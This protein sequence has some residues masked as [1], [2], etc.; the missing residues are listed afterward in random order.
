MA[1]DS[2]SQQSSRG[3]M[4]S[5]YANLLDPST[6]STA[7]TPGTISRAPVV[8]KQPAGDESQQDEA[9][10]RKHQISAENIIAETDCSRVS[11]SPLCER[12]ASLRFQPTKRPQITTQ[13]PKSKPSLPK[14]APPRPVA[15]PPEATFTPAN[16]SVRSVVKTTLAD[17]TAA[18]DDDDVNGFYGGEKRQRG[19]R[20]KR[21]KN[22]E[23][24]H[25]PQNWDDIYEPS[26]PN[27]Y[28]EYKNS[29]EKIREVR[30]WKDR[31]YAHRMARKHSSDLDSEDEEQQRT[32]MSNQFAPPTMSFAPPP[33]FD[34]PATADSRPSAAIPEYPTG[35]DAYTRRLRLSQQ[36]HPPSEA[37]VA[38]PPP[39]PPPL[40]QPPVNDPISS[41]PPPPKEPL[42]GT[43]S[44]APVRYN[45]PSAP[46][47]L[48]KSEAE[49]EDALQKE[50]SG[51]EQEEDAPRS[52]RPGQKGFAERLMSKYGW[53]KGS[54][55]GA[56]GSGI[57]NPLRVQI[58][59]QKKKPDAEGGGF[60]GPGGRGKI[61]GGKKKKNADGGADTEEGKFGAMSEVIVLRGM[62]NGMDLDA[63][64]ESAGDGGL[65]QEI[66]EECGEKY[67]RVER[68][69]IDRHNPS[70][71][72]VFV[73]FTSQLSALRAVNA[74]EG[75]IFNGNTISARFFDVEKFEKGIYE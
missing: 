13:K 64:L 62:V 69:F 47:D 25:V 21:K 75:R 57:V 24:S 58:E 35:E 20:K 22:R 17:W 34:E 12:T 19:G 8:F 52:V 65:M 11:G 53:T 5:L 48:P 63:E 4:V 49:L 29:D 51:D 41:P 67:G 15:S 60:V 10:A 32:Q 54:G 23:E 1:P 66:G 70:T 30:E 16:G 71:A 18:G 28:E 43:I 3:G 37:V 40:D 50:E 55:L 44:R 39:P 31:L 72:P 27:N 59:K 74:L 33:D 45:L 38:M 36:L 9:S 7:T 68:V 61:I 14:S 26:R 6:S 46:S 42:A 73:K 2:T 56:S